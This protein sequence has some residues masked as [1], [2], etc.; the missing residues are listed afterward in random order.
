MK[1]AVSILLLFLLPAG[2]FSDGKTQ[3]SNGEN[4]RYQ[5]GE[6]LKY[7][8]HFGF[9]KGGIASVVLEKEIYEGQNVYHSRMMAK[10]TGIVDVLYKVLDI[11]ECYF[12]IE[13]GLPIKSL[14]NISEG[15]YKYYNEIDFNR[16]D[17]IVESK[18]S[19]P[20][21][22]PDNILDMVST[23]YL[24][25]RLDYDTL[26]VGD[27][28]KVNTFFDDEIFPFDIRFR[29]TETIRT[30]LGKFDCYKFVPFVEPGRIFESEDDMTIWVSRDSNSVPI[31]IKFD[32]IVGSV[33]C[34][35][36]EYSGLT[37][38]LIGAKK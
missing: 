3:V 27:V 24:I 28:I 14:R 11:Y 26:K 17:N 25:R 33:K 13:N 6:N 8:I 38:K 2:M 35:L 34:D 16:E 5:N 32:L 22:V 30:K 23:F 9:L 10:T 20:H 12:S 1:V 31:R 36:I 4:T 21:E 37:S 29:G 19:G 15:R 7:L 18:K